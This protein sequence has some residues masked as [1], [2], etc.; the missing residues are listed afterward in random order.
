MHVR[1]ADQA[2]WPPS[3][4]ELAAAMGISAPRAHQLIGKLGKLQLL[5]R[6]DGGH[7]KARQW[8]ATPAG[9]AAVAE[10]LPSKA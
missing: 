4:R 3:V 5:E 8:R 2:G 9:R 1:L 7:G 6:T 10:L